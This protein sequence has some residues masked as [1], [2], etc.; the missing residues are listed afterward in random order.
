MYLQF[1]IDKAAMISTGLSMAEYDGEFNF[2]CPSMDDLI[3]VS[4][5][6][7]KLR[8]ITSADNSQLFKDPDWLR[9]V[10]ADG[11]KFNKQSEGKL[12]LGY[13][14]DLFPK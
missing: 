5:L 13:D 10:V 8:H 3:G 4:N 1:R 7:S 12:M 14:T 11:A 6:R 2:W 9:E